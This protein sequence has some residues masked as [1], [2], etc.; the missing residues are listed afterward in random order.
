MLDRLFAAFHSI[1]GPWVVGAVFFFSA[2]ESALFVGFL[3][4]GE[5]VVFLGGVLASR[6][7]L[8]LAAVLVASVT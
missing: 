7:H 2:A 3:L 1:P 5:L 8:P 4:P 6:A